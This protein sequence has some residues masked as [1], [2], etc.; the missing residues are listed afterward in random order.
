MVKAEM[1]IERPETQTGL[2]VVVRS[3]HPKDTAEKRHGPP[4]RIYQVL[5]EALRT[6]PRLRM[7]LSEC[8]NFLHRSRIVLTNNDTHR[9]PMGPAYLETHS[10]RLFR[11][12]RS[13][14][15]M[16]DIERI[17]SNRPSTPL[18]WIAYRDS[19]EAGAEWA[20]S[21]LNSGTLDSEHQALLIPRGLSDS[22]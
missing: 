17:S 20:V 22:R 18:D 6:C 9:V 11:N 16:R 2:S 7:F 1:N 15:C 21:I 4:S 10:G 5:F 13:L 12:I 8:R 14:A 19:W 3:A